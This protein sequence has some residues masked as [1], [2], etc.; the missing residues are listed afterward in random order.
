MKNNKKTIL[1]TGASSGIGRHAALRLAQDGHHVFAGVRRKKDKIETEN[2]HPNIKGVYI[3]VA[4]Q[5]SIDKAFWYV[6]KNTDKLDVLINNAGIVTAGPVEFL[7]IK[8][9]KQQFDINTFGA[10]SV[11][12]RFTPLLTG[13]RIINISSVAASGLF[14]YLSP[15]CASKRA[16][17]I[18]MNS[19]ALENKNN[20]KV[21]SIKPAA[22]KTP[23]W[24]KSIKLCEEAF[25]Q[26]QES[27]IKKYEKELYCM[28]KLAQSAAEKGL[29]VSAVIDKIVKA[30]NAE[31]PKS[32]YNA[33][34]S[35]Y[36]AHLASLLPQGVLNSII[37]TKLKCIDKI[38][39]KS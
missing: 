22:I 26:L 11:S 38:R 34:F 9:L 37:R 5:A 6:L 32:S 2:L 36:I 10:V 4:N 8:H 39:I 18:I 30:V 33:G 23:L 7:D 19:F 13:G 3:D 25:S 31:N 35:V 20:I 28:K 17:D 15:Y 29:E 14:P 12:K 24:D 21:I 27:E 1:I 16:M